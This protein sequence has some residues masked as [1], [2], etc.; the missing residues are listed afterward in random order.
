ML[1]VRTSREDPP[2]PGDLAELA[3]VLARSDTET[4][5]VVASVS[6]NAVSSLWA[7]LG[8]LVPSA[9]AA[10]ARSV[11]LVVSGA[12]S[13]SPD[14]PA[15]AY[16]LADAWETDVLAPDGN[17]VIVPGGTLFVPGSGD[18]SRGWRRFTPR[19]E[20]VFLGPRMPEP[21]WQSA[22]G[23]L[24][25]RT[26]SRCVVEQIP[27]GVLI[28]PLQAPSG[29]PDDLGDALHVDHLRPT[30]LVG[31]PGAPTVP[32]IAVA[33]VLSALPAELRHR[34]RL[35]PGAGVDLLPL[36]QQVADLLGI[37]VEVLTG[38]PVVVED[39][40][41]HGGAPEVRVVLV[42]D[43]G[44]L[45]WQPFVQA[46]A[47]S[48]ASATGER[49]GP[50]LLAWYPPMPGWDGTGNGA[51]QLTDSWQVFV[52]RAGLS[53]ETAGHERP[54]PDG[55]AVDVERMTIE[56]GTPGGPLD[57][58]VLPALARLFDGLG[59]ELLGGAVMCVR[60]LCG[61]DV[62]SEMRTLADRYGVFLPAPGA[63]GANA[64]PAPR[65]EV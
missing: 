48:P 31:V 29:G 28:R 58:T 6:R 47:C 10:G 53:V 35:A 63:P 1:L 11:R 62:V 34:V 41:P 4:V 51:V 7:R 57:V 21:S 24:P 2:G 32:A 16:E 12:G 25:A 65:G 30:V 61:Q 8:E 52:T 56:V 49:S 27:A 13:G 26:R 33:E 64:P 38:L 9:R 39:E 50:R 42:G 54:S 59:A 20:S 36:G 37:E 44:Q 18:Q 23:V 3:G 46:V 15:A 40:S 43:D 17:V 45:T 5:T 19:G 60:G 14:S 55:R 22:L